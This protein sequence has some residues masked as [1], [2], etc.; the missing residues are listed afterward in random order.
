MGDYALRLS[1]SEM[2]RYQGMAQRARETESELWR[3]A[4]ITSGAHVVDVGCGPG[5]TMVA[6][7]GVVGAEGSV[8][9][10][11]ADLDAVVRANAMIAAEG[12][13]RASARVGQADA[14]GLDPAAYDVAVLRH[15]LAHNGDREQAIVDHLATPIRPGGCVYLVDVEA[16]MTRMWPLVPEVVELLERYHA[17]HAGQGNDLQV[18]LRLPDLLREAGLEV[19]EHRGQLLTLTWQPGDR[20]P[21]WAAR[22]SMVDT[23]FATA[24]DL[25]RW[26]EVFIAL[27][28]G[29]LRPTLF[30]AGFVAIGRR[31]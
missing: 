25:A 21:A 30:L 28:A 29:E 31:R 20:G 23:G 14:T 24:D 16:S 17:F 12:L 9:G 4:G 11:D 19:L 6:M 1:E 26:D 13:A 8:T 10:V 3:L 18:G 2:A 7:A 27:D 22:D 5:A 15:V